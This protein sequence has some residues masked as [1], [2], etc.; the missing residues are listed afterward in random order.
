[1]KSL[2]FSFLLLAGYQ[3]FS[4]NIYFPPVTNS[5]WET[6]SLQEAGFCSAN[7][8]ALYDYL[9]ETNTDAFLL[10]KDGKIVIEK[11]FGD[12]TAI[13]PHVWNSAGKSLMAFAVGVAADLDSLNIND[14][15]TDYLGADWTD[16]PET[17]DSIRIIH[18]LTMTSGLSD[19]T[20]DP[21]CTA[22]ECLGC[23]ADPATR[24]DYHNGPYTLLGEVI[25]AAVGQDLNDFVTER[26]KRPTGM[27]G[28][29]R[30]FGDNR[31][32]ISN[33][34]SMAR[35]GLLMLNGG[36]WDGTPVLRDANYVNAMTNSSQDLNKSY[37]YLWWLNGKA[38]Y[39]L[40]GLQFSFPGP[41][42]PDAPAETYAAIGKNGQI[43]NVVPSQGLVVVRMGDTPGDGSL[44][45]SNYNDSIWV[46]IN[47]LDCAT[48]V[49]GVD[50]NNEVKVFPNPA[51][52]D[53]R[54]SA[55]TGLSWVTI[56]DGSG[57]SLDRFRL[58]GSLVDINLEGF[59]KGLLHLR[60]V[61]RSGTV[62]WRRVVRQ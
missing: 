31:I 24:W 47:D 33:A 21:F 11:Y 18:Q 54:L 40:P 7:E 36:T 55:T 50:L 38:S 23:L 1:M 2:F 12:F 53:V 60:I 32:F 3:L 44:V 41:I 13:S 59:P 29:Y 28:Q 20:G 51:T 46:R 5:N 14:R 25:E 57:K 43:I 34:R 49:A 9:A 48:S 22:P 37:G 6:M 35:F 45:S 10:L 17:E 42:M 8:Q 58:S 26:I 62:L 27:T 52:T 4:Q 15:T 56:Y 16:C 30:Y 19:A 61:T 39:Q